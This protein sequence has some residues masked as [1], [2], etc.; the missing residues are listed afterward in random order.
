MAEKTNEKEERGHPS[1][2]PKAW[3]NSYIFQ[4]IVEWEENLNFKE[5]HI[6]VDI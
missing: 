1:T 5:N 2:S 3:E 4:I 6:P